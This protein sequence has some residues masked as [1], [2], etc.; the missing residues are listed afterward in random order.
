VRLIV[1][2]DVLGPAKT[3]AVAGST[4]DGPRDDAA[5][6]AGVR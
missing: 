6:L 3:P 2:A 5:E 1:V 4:L